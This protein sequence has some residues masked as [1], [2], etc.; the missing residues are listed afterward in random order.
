MENV[1]DKI[2]LFHNWKSGTSVRSS[3]FTLDQ[4]F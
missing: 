1:E 2:I 3:S 4:P